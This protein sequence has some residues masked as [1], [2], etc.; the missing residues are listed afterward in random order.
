MD[1]T[2]SGRKALFP[3]ESF[4]LLLQACSLSVEYLS[5]MRII[6]QDDPTSS[7]PYGIFPHESLT[8]VMEAMS[9]TDYSLLHCPYRYF[10]SVKNER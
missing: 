2:Q 4:S 6:D 10:C 3:K 7:K 1:T 9:I 8:Q 5:E